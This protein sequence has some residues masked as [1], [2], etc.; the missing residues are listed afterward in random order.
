MK[1]LHC[2]IR[3]V[4]PLIWAGAWRAVSIVASVPPATPAPVVLR[5]PRRLTPV[6]VISTVRPSFIEGTSLARTVP[7]DG[8]EK[9]NLFIRLRPTLSSGISCRSVECRHAPRRADPS[10]GRRRGGNVRRRP[11]LAP[12]RPSPSRQRSPRPAPVLRILR[13][14]SRCRRPRV[15]ASIVVPAAPR[16]PHGPAHRRGIRSVSVRPHQEWRRGHR[17]PG[18]AGIRCP[19][20]GRRHRPPRGLRALAVETTLGWL[21]ATLTPSR[22]GYGARLIQTR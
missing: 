14:V 13:R 18:N 10:S 15:L 19:T 17:S 20:L 22:V 9:V 8:S 5:N 3:R 7:V 4:V 1:W 2:K 11:R 12:D 6:G 16:G 21:N